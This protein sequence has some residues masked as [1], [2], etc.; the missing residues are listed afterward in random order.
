MEK[1][2]ICG[3]GGLVGS[4]LVELCKDKFETF[5]SFNLRDPNFNNVK[6]F[7][8]DITNHE[9]LQHII[10]ETRPDIIINATALNNVDYCEEHENEANEVNVKAVSILSEI[11]NLLNIKLVHLSTDSVFDGTKKEAYHELDHPNPINNYGRSKLLGENEVLEFKNNLVV[12]ASVLYGWL[13]KSLSS[14]KTSSLKQINFA[15]WLISKLKL[16]EKVNITSEEFSSPIIADDF[17]KS[18]LH[19]ILNK[20]SGIFHSA[21]SLCINRYDFSI[22]LANYLNLDSSL[23][24]PTT[25]EK[26]GR[27]VTTANNKCLNSTKLINT[28]YKFLTLDE[29][30]ALIKQQM[31]I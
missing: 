22:K 15:Q 1:I 30:F 31:L 10:K 8:L 13:P 26:L 9:K 24:I 12:R 20:K 23:I 7:Q 16:K 25:T 28:N 21:P 14:Q 3:I 6:S 27:G 4:K 18:I 11:S 29:S 2:F 5:G 19:L 17:A